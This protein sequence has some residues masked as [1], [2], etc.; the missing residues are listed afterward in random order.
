MEVLLSIFPHLG[1]FSIKDVVPNKEGESSKIKVKVRLNIH[2][3]LNVVN[4]SLVEKLPAVAEPEA[5]SMEVEGQEDK[6]K[7]AAGDAAPEVRRQ[8]SSFLASLGNLQG[9]RSDFSCLRVTALCCTFNMPHWWRFC[10]F[11]RL[12]AFRTGVILA[13]QSSVFSWW[14]LQLPSLILTAAED[15]GEKKFW[16]NVMSKGQKE[17]DG[18]GRGNAFLA[19][20][21]SSTS[22]LYKIPLP[23]RPDKMLVIQRFDFCGPLC[24]A[25]GL[26]TVLWRR[27]C[28]TVNLHGNNF[29]PRTPK[30]HR[31]LMNHKTKKMPTSRWTRR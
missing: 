23:S 22:R 4:A 8:R 3:I 13:S 18:R 21:I 17:G 27:T 30:G 16:T 24:Q 29:Y 12:I 19:R 9:S 14:K 26:R 1:R 25:L 15:W 2:G 6:T 31:N 7:E 28:I 20:Q 5:E 11:S 10:L